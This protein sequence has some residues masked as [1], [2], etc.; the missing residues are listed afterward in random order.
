[1]FKILISSF[2]FSILTAIVCADIA[3]ILWR[4][5]KIYGN[6]S[7]KW[8]MIASWLLAAGYVVIA[9]PRLAFSFQ[10]PA[11]LWAFPLSHVFFFSALAFLSLIPISFRFPGKEKYVLYPLLVGAIVLTAWLAVNFSYDSVLAVSYLAYW[12]MEPKL[13]WGTAGVLLAIL[14][15]SASIFFSAIFNSRYRRGIKIRSLLFAVGL[16]VVAVGMG[17]TY[18]WTSSAKYPL[19]QFIDIIGFIL[20]LVGALYRPEARPAP[21]YDI[22]KSSEQ[23]A[24]RASLD[25]HQPPE[26][27]EWQ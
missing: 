23:S 22:P 26:F 1:M 9:L 6:P 20:V 12:Y 7:A 25:D 21:T 24:K 19:H 11:M 27:T 10:N 15:F 16:I 5:Y 18:L 13:A 14:L 8:L 3:L 2:H 4:S 17:M